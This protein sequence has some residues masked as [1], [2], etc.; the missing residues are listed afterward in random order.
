MAK[1]TGSHT[2]EGMPEGPAPVVEAFT[3]AIQEGSDRTRAAMERSM[4][5]WS[6]ESERFVAEMSRDNATLMEALHAC[7][8]PLDVL[9]VE[10]AWVMVRSRA[11]LG[12]ASRLFE[13]GVRT[14]ESI[15]PGAGAA[16]PA[17]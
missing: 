12:T 7:R 9:A 15:A 3:T 13:S 17:R 6:S 2:S 10:Q 11:Y 4:A 8:S 5:N 1:P 16:P 14:A